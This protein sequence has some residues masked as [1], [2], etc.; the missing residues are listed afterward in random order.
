MKGQG[1]VGYNS[2]RLT[3]NVSSYLDVDKREIF[4][5]KVR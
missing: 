2:F 3:F 4:K 1:K 5:E